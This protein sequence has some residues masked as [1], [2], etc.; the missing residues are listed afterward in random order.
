MV[1]CESSP[2][3]CP[4]PSTL[5][6]VSLTMET[7]SPRVRGGLQHG[8]KKKFNYSLLPLSRHYWK[9]SSAQS[10]PHLFLCQATLR[11]SPVAEADRQTSRQTNPSP[12][13]QSFT[14][15]AK[16][17]AKATACAVQTSTGTTREGW[18]LQICTISKLAGNFE[19]SECDCS[20]VW[21]FHEIKHWNF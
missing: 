17:T 15:T 14:L 6:C 3:P 19:S 8:E 16:N 4:H 7:F 18:A 10:A 20:S 2:I 5:T 11:L 9:L 1:A 21:C 12:W 13:S